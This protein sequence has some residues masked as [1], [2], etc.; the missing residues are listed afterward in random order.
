MSDPAQSFSALD[1]LGAVAKSRVLRE[2]VFRG[3]EDL[4]RMTRAVEERDPA[5]ARFAAHRIRGSSLVV[6]ATRLAECCLTV[7]SAD[8]EAAVDAA[9]VDAIRASL[10]VT[11]RDVERVLRAHP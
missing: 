3:E 8:D 10:A 7:E 9:L 6:G 4:A 5:A 2:F 1:E 11:S